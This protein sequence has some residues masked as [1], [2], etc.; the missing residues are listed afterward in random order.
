MRLSRSLR[1][2]RLL[3]LL[4][5]LRLLRFLMPEKSLSIYN[6]CTFW[7]SWRPKR[8]R[9]KSKKKQNSEKKWKEKR[10]WFSVG[11][12][13]MEKSNKYIISWVRV[14]ASIKWLSQVESSRLKNGR[15]R[16]EYPS[17]QAWI[18]F[19]LLG[20]LNPK[21]IKRNVW[22]GLISTITYVKQ[23]VFAQLKRCNH[24]EGL[25]QWFTDITKTYCPVL[26]F[27]LQL[28]RRCCGCWCLAALLHW[29]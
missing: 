11:G 27:F 6:A 15:V 22:S 23:A 2:L 14:T 28:H 21:S 25:Y 1:P 19:L 17:I 24:K 16:V 12:F 29:P 13:G 26:P 7:F 18:Y 4:R 5:S 20:A 9:I 8:F 3:R 10:G